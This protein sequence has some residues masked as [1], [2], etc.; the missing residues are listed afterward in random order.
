[1]I[2]DGALFALDGEPIFSCPVYGMDVSITNQAFQLINGYDRGFLPYAGGTYDQPN[3]LMTMI[4]TVNSAK[5]SRAEEEN[6]GGV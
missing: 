3:R 6:N 5:I 4:D 1:M 2:P